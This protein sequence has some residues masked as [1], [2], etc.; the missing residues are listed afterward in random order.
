[1]GRETEGRP[2]M[3]YQEPPYDPYQQQRPDPYQPQQ[4]PDPYQPQQ[5]QQQPQYQYPQQPYSAQPYSPYPP[6]SGYSGYGPPSTGQ[7]NTM[8]ILSLVFA[9]IFSPLGIVFGHIAKKQ[10]RE[11]N[12]EGGGLATAGLVLGYIFTGIGLLV[13]AFYVILIVAVANHAGTTG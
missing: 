2:S 11:R 3:S 1:M 7:T 6:T 5:P 4:Q 10:I 12:E 9:F 13:C 8:A